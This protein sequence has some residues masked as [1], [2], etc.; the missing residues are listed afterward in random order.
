VRRRNRH[1]R[2]KAPLA[3]NKEEKCVTKFCRNRKALKSDGYFLEHCWKCRSRQAKT[4]NPVSYVLNMLRHSAKKRKLPFTLTIESFA[5]FCKETG[6][7]EKRG[8]KPGSMTI[9]RRDWN[10]GYHIWNMQVMTHA[11][12]SAQGVDNTRRDERGCVTLGE[13]EPF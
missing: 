3:R 1:K 10:E 12:N 6:Y 8:N 2:K 11:D 4:K 9:D 5:E 7:L 13:N